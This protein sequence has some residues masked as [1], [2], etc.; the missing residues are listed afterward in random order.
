M[1]LV[2][3]GTTSGMIS[4]GNASRAAIKKALLAIQL[5]RKQEEQNSELREN[6]RLSGPAL[7]AVRTTRRIFRPADHSSEAERVNTNSSDS[8][9]HNVFKGGTVNAQQRK[10][11]PL[12]R[13]GSRGVSRSQH[14]LASAK[15]DGNNS[16]SSGSD[17]PDGKSETKATSGEG[18]SPGGEGTVHLGLDLEMQRPQVST[19]TLPV[20]PFG[21]GLAAMKVKHRLQALHQEAKKKPSQQSSTSTSTELSLRNLAA[22]KAQQS[23]KEAAAAAAQSE[24]EAQQANAMAALINAARTTLPNFSSP[25]DEAEEAE[26]MGMLGE[27]D[28]ELLD[29]VKEVQRIL[30]WLFAD[31]DSDFDSQ[32]SHQELKAIFLR[33]PQPLGSSLGMEVDIST[34][35]GEK[36]LPFSRSRFIELVILVCVRVNQS[37]ILTSRL[38]DVKRFVGRGNSAA[39]RSLDTKSGSTERLPEMKVS[40]LSGVPRMESSPAKSKWL[41]AK[42]AVQD[43][44]V[45]RRKSQSEEEMSPL[46]KL[47][48]LFAS[49]RKS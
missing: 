29:L 28:S 33:A 27:A 3:A 9:G 21:S 14:S 25:P 13:A 22:E 31:A 18:R 5:T 44:V 49:V 12:R 35:Q 41:S 20:S 17:T 26:I 10:R 1:Q 11:E 24:K 45:E 37:P 7:P 40:L 32:L 30:R 42:S 8:F 36:N 48:S 4:G 43:V 19:P 34:L 16:D 46:K 39:G 38:A 2:S 23:E 47:E 6:E 15:E